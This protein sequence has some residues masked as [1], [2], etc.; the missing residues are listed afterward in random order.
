MK[1]LQKNNK[2]LIVIILFFIIPGYSQW[3][4]NNEIEISRDEIHKYAERKYIRNNQRDT[5]RYYEDTII[6]ENKIVIGNIVVI[7]GDLT[8]KGEVDGDILVIFGDVYIH[9][10]AI[11]TGNITSIDGHIKQYE[12]SIITGNQIETSSTNVFRKTSYNS[13]SRTTTWKNSFKDK[14]STLPLGELEDRVLVRYNRVQ[15]F[16]LGL[17]LPKNLGRKYQ[18]FSIHGFGGYGF[19]EKTWRYQLGVDRYFFNQRDYRF[20]IGAKVYDLT[21]T[22]DDWIITPLENTLAAV[23]IHEDFQ[24]FYRR[25]GI[26]LHI[27]QNWTIFLKGTLYYRNDKYESVSKNTDW[28][29]FGGKKFFRENPEIDVGRMHSI[30][31]EIYLDTRNDHQLPIR[32]W[33]GKLIMEMSNSK[34]SSDF[35]FNQYILELRHYMPLSRGERLDLRVKLGSS[36]GKLPLQKLFELGGISSL[37]AHR[38]KEFQGN[39][40]ILANFEY[41]ISPRTIAHDILFLSDLRLIL[42]S[43]IGCAW[44]DKTNN[45]LLDG[46]SLLA[47]EHFKSDIG[48]AITDYKGQYRLNIA[49]KTDTS[50]NPITITF[51]IAKPF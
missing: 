42:F 37:R 13:E 51:R 44:N 49:K 28:A 45:N 7:K 50:F 25:N 18:Y 15:G 33:Y 10:H 6:D 26:E 11:V 48:I 27:S 9:N 2:Y 32:G 17:E 4:E 29:I 23:L 36:E 24:D 5:Y 41:N 47:W 19:K 16:F 38:Y 3:E 34:I 40:M 30:I 20:E 46:F 12:Y 31:G 22:R 35:F 14:Y 1:W 21:D 43:D 8:I 39:R